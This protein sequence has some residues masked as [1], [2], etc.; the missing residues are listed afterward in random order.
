MYLL[1]IETS[2]DDT[3][4]AVLTI[5]DGQP[6]ACS[7]IVSTQ[8]VHA[9]Y[10]GVVPELASRAHA[11]NIIPTV[12][13]ALKT[14]GITQGELTH[15]AYTNTPGLPGSL[16]VGQQFAK[17]LSTALR[18]PLL[19]V[20]HLIGHVM[21]VTLT[22]Q[23]TYPFLCLLVSGGN[24]QIIRVDAPNQIE[25]LGN[26]IDDAAGEAFDKCAKMLQLPY[27][28]GVQIDRLAEQGNPL[29]YSFARPR[30]KGYDYSFSGVKT[31]VLYFLRDRLQEDPDFI[32]NNKADLCASI[33]HTIVDILM[34]K[35]LRAATDT[36]I[37]TIALAG[38]VSANSLLRRRTQEEAEQ[39]GYTAIIPPLNLTTDNAAMIG[40]S[41]VYQVLQSEQ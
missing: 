17:G 32:E 30:I 36:G 25:I 26:T 24:S 39:R 5:R 9:A 37:T 40:A 35:F 20:N 33:R 28:G 19:P 14:A 29:A 21:A 11:Q 7:N 41:A 16:I 18:L 15:I 12:S 27:P 22:E 6:V 23:M 31:S 10:G 4:A 8:N 38:G 13:Q 2:C 3:A 1:A 34:D